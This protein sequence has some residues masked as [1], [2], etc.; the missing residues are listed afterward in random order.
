MVL[1]CFLISDADVIPREPP[2]PTPT[3]ATPS[4]FAPSTTATPDRPSQHAHSME[5]TISNLDDSSDDEEYEEFEFSGSSDDEEADE[6][7]G[8]DAITGEEVR[9]MTELYDSSRELFD[10]IL[11]CIVS[12]HSPSQNKR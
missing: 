12:C 8:D 3:L 11:F 9:C 7:E 2:T 1:R 10:L 6:A 4:S 5:A